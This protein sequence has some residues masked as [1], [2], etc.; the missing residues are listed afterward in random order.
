MQEILF[1][2]WPRLPTM[3]EGLVHEVVAD[4]AASIPEDVDVPSG[5]LKELVQAAFLHQHDSNRDDLTRAIKEL[6]NQYGYSLG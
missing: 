4:V 5:F 6:L 3:D 1:E 2:L